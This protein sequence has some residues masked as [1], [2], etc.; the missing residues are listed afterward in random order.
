MMKQAVWSVDWYSKVVL[1]IIAISL[2][3]LLVRQL[4]G[5][6]EVKPEREN[7]AREVFFLELHPAGREDALLH[8]VD[9]ETYTRLKDAQGDIQVNAVLDSL[10]SGEKYRQEKFRVKFVTNDFIILESE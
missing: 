7:K 1:T 4:L 8:I 2:V 5:K 9:G 6:V 10:Y 3:G